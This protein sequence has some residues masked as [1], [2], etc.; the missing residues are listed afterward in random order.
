MAV[1]VEVEAVT[2]AS[3]WHDFGYRLHRTQRG[4][5]P[6][7][8]LAQNREIG[9]HAGLDANH[10]G[11]GNLRLDLDPSSLASLMMEGAD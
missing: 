5:K 7:G 1:V 8:R 4:L 11:L 3:V 2:F 9:W 10:V 6:P